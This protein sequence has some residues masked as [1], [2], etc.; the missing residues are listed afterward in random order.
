MVDAAFEALWKNVLDHWDDDRAHG[1]FLEHCQATD[2]LASAAARYRGMKGDRD[3]GVVAEKRLAGVAI[4]AL[5]K[6]E[7]TRTRPH[8]SR[9]R[10]G[11]LVAATI[12][13]LATALL[14]AYVLLA[15]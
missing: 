5:A 7:G 8:P 4:V 11:T 15:R 2:Q 1:A 6:L 14:L 12:F 3:R 10:T 9:A 13:G